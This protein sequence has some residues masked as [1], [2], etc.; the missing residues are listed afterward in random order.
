MTTRGMPIKTGPNAGGT[1]RSVDR[2]MFVNA[3]ARDLN[4][5]SGPEPSNMLVVQ[6][7]D[8]TY[9]SLIGGGSYVTREDFQTLSGAANRQTTGGGS[10]TPTP[11]PKPVDTTVTQ[12]PGA[13]QVEG[14]GGRGGGSLLAGNVR[15]STGGV[16]RVGNRGRLR[17]KTSLIG[18]A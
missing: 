17:R 6:R 9:G 15:T 11:T 12:Q 10:G 3:P 2:G 16:D 18:G 4:R 1:I 5:N 14:T 8:G 7:Q 13:V